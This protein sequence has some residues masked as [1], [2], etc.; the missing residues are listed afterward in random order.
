[1]DIPQNPIATITLESGDVI[2]L[3]LYPQVAP[4]TVCNFISLANSGF[5]DGVIFHRIIQ[6][7]VLQGGDPNGTGMGGPGYSI[8]GEF[9]SN[10][11]ENDIAH[12]EG[13][14]SM[15]RAASYNSGGSQFFLVVGD[16][17]FLDGDYAGFGKTVDEAS[18]EVCM[19]LSLVPTGAQDRPIDPPVIKSITVDTFG[20]DYP[21][22]TKLN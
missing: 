19:Q 21:E 14:I 16:A 22:P 3:E 11:H 8:E 15:A 20:Y 10:G 9:S 4:Q 12:T 1:M 5:Y 2:K 17:R 13:V 18:T 7:F 6:G